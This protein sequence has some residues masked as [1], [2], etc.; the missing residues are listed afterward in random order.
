MESILVIFRAIHTVFMKFDSGP[1]G[2]IVVY[3]RFL[4][5]KLLCNVFRHKYV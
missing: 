3:M 4:D 1:I 5:Q 2:P